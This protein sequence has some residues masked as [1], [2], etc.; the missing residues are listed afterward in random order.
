M[1][2]VT[3]HTDTHT[4]THMHTHTQSEGGG[5]GVGMGELENVL[6]FTPISIFISLHKPPAVYTYMSG[7]TI[8]ISRTTGITFPADSTSPRHKITVSVKVA[9]KRYR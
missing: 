4:H 6:L 2:D 9:I 5:E 3:K 7:E 1:S 8:N